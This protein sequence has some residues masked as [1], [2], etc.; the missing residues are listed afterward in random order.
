MAEY[1][2]AALKHLTIEQLPDGEGFFIATDVLPGVWGHGATIAE[3][4]ADFSW[5][6]EGWVALAF[7]RGIEIPAIEGVRPTMQAA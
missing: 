4:L 6:V 3:A 1:M 5:G 7:Q 2:N